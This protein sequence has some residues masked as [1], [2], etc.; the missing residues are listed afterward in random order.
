[1][2]TIWDKKPKPI[3]IPKIGIYYDAFAMDAFHKEL[4]AYI[5]RVLDTCS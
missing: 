5:K 4:K 1:M 2:E 3:D